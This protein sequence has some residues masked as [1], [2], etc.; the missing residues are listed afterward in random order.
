[1]RAIASFAGL[2]L[3]LAA[4]VCI[5][6]NEAGPAADA[7]SASG[8]TSGQ[9]VSWSDPEFERIAAALS[10][11]WKTTG[12]VSEFGDASQSSEVVMAIAPV[13]LSELPDAL[14]VETARA[15][16]PARP[17][18]H[19]ILQLYRRQGEIRMRT[20][21][22]RDPNSNVHN[23]LVG[24]WA[25]PEYM[26]DLPV[27]AFIG[28]LDLAIEPSG[29][30]FTASTPYPYPTAMGGA[31][32]MTSE[33]T[34]SGDQLRT[35][36]RGYDADGNVVWGAGEDDAYV[37]QRADHPFQVETSEIGLT[38]IT[39]YEDTTT[40][41]AG[42]GDQ[43]AFQ[44]SGWLTTGTMFDTSRRQGGRPLQY[45]LPGDPIE[46]WKLGTEGMSQGD[47]RKLI[48]PSS[49]GYGNSSAAGGRIPAGS[50][51]IFEAECVYVAK[52]EDESGE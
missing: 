9:S 22:I 31:V 13:T 2:G 15:D 28:T 38:T 49:L 42:S 34:L 23:L 48:V 16:S 26:P 24:L 4:T 30:G 33:M 8:E 14:L 10:G 27:S 44:Y 46:G 19:A 3:M 1:M 52:P 41:P 45:K 25:A 39:L 29:S 50:T 21:E 17:Y 12:Q 11:T 35:E 40:E 32:E 6:Q 5:A 51:L 36:D 20:L 43:V 18:R 47:W 37:F 7:P